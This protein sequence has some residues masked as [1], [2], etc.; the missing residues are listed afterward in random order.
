MIM[1][2]VD[3]KRVSNKYFIADEQMIKALGE[4]KVN[5]DVSAASTDNIEC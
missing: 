3:G 1:L 5:I 4:H 2:Y